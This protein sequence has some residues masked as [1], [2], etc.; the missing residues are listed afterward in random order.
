M[1]TV[2]MVQIGLYHLLFG[3][4]VVALDGFVPARHEVLG[5]SALWTGIVIGGYNLA[6]ISRIPFGLV[7]DSKLLFSR[8]RTSY[9]VVGNLVATLGFLT[10]PLVVASPLLLISVVIF[11]LGLSLAGP[12]ADAL[13][14]DLSTKEERPKVASALHSLRILGFAVGG[15]VGTVLHRL[16]GFNILFYVF[17]A[18]MLVLTFLSVYRVP[19]SGIIEKNPITSNNQLKTI[20][21]V[22]KLKE[23]LARREALFMALFLFVFQIGLFMQ[24]AILER[25]GIRELHMP[26]EQAGTLNAVWAIGTLF[27]IIFTGFFLIKRIGKMAAAYIGIIIAVIGLFLISIVETL[28]QLYIATFVFGIGSGIGSIPPISLMMDISEVG[29]TA[30]TMIAF[31]GLIDA[32][33]K[34]IAAFLGGGGG[35][36][37]GYRPIFQIEILVFLI[38]LFLLRLTWFEHIKA[39]PP[40]FEG[41]TL[42]GN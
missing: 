10:I 9:L 29:G 20:L 32:L 38:A 42:S 24:N 18:V 37:L 34:G 23:N 21:R 35:Q 4:A 40:P 1:R 5:I 7:S 19:D 14:I 33:G 22:Y 15:M 11:A 8:R 28:C 13:L 25:F 30:A 16:W 27:A 17:G 31:Y 3:I 6:E 12:A 2:H 41:N 26:E 39:N 36:I